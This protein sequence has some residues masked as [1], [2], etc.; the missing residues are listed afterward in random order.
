MHSIQGYSRRT[1]YV[2][3]DERLKCLLNERVEH[4]KMQ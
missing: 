2:I 1:A 3:C 4:Y